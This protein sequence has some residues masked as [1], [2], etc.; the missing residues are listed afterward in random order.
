MRVSRRKSLGHPQTA[1]SGSPTTCTVYTSRQG[2][3]V[4]RS[5][6]IP[7]SHFPVR[8][9]ASLSSVAVGRRWSPSPWYRAS[10]GARRES[11]VT[12]L[13]RRG[14]I[15]RG[16][17]RHRD[18]FVRVLDVEARLDTRHSQT[19]ANIRGSAGVRCVRVR[20]GKGGN[21]FTRGETGS[22]ARCIVPGRT[23]MT[24]KTRRRRRG[25]GG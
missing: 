19:F 8:S 17:A 5:V 7:R 22:I 2:A 20:K 25:R 14:R 1:A 24:T 21:K 3:K 10:S 18:R 12:R 6:S 13:T 11:F 16:L 23:A 4:P 15:K 9:L